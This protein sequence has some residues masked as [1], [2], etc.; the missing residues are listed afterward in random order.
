MNTF[1]FR[2]IQHGFWGMSTLNRTLKVKADTLEQAQANVFARED[3][4]TKL[5]NGDVQSWQF[6][7]E[8][9]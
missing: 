6:E 1:V 4:R 9:A 7:S 8:K 5:R 3:F 2:R